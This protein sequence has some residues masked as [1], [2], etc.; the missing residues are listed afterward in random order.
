MMQD[1][2]ITIGKEV[3]K[4]FPTS[5]DTLTPIPKEENVSG[6]SQFTGV[7]IEKIMGILVKKQL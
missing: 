1:L 5:L 3:L 6:S 2:D 7:T 4:L